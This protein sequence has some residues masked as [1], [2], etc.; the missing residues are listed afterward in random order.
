MITVQPSDKLV[1]QSVLF[2]G[3]AA[4]AHVRGIASEVVAEL[5]PPDPVPEPAP[6]ERDVLLVNLEAEAHASRLL[7]PR[8]QVHDAILAAMDSTRRVLST[9]DVRV[10]PSAP[11]MALAGHLLRVLQEVNAPADFTPKHD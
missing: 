4:F 5:F 8:S 7:Y 11:L 10:V 1:G 9:H 6:S 2:L 3:G